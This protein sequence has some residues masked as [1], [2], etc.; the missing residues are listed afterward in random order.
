MDRKINQQVGN[1]ICSGRHKDLTKT[2]G[3]RKNF[4]SQKSA[5]L[6]DGAKCAR[7]VSQ[8]QRGPEAPESAVG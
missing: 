5:N 2:M 7:D 8:L 6:D 1:T 4:R 3:A